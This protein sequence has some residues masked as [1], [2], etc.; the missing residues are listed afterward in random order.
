MTSRRLSLAGFACACGLALWALAQAATAAREGLPSKL[1]D[2]E[3]WRLIDD[4]SEANGYFSSDNLVSN[5]DTFQFVIPRL[6]ETTKPGGV[7]LG[8]GPD[9]NF[10]YIVALKPRIVF[11][12]DIRRGNLDAHLMYK[13]LIEL[14]SDRAEF[15]SRLFSRQRPSGLGVGST[16][17][18]LFSAYEPVAASRALYDQNW[19][20]IM[21]LLTRQHG[22]PLDEG[23]VS[24]IEH[25]YRSFFEA[26]PS[27]SYAMGGSGRGFMRYP[28]YQDLQMADDGEGKTRGYLA[29]EENFKT[30]K[31]IEHDN[32][33]VPVVGDF[34]GPKAL[35]SVGRYLADHGAT[36][37]A[38]Y[39]SNVEQYLF[40]NGVWAQFARNVATIPQDPSSTFIRSCFNTCQ[41]PVGSRSVSLLDSMPELLKDFNEGR[42]LSYSQV[43]AH[44]R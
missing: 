2:Q 13:A 18:A 39:L 9:Q 22:G 37:T 11:I 12:T 38:F 28:S 24:G 36:V 1:T 30:L 10:T 26:G 40:Q 16:A 25:V 14:S 33:I 6:L 31:A 15:L 19:S 7:Y 43:L 21:A 29:S 27:L 8:V 35:R 34:A 20:A 4:F 42:I 3:F 44:S 32:L 23:D 41:S 5:E 17:A